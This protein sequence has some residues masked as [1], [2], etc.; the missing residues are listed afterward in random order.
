EEQ[1]SLGISVILDAVFPRPE[2]RLKMKALADH[3]HAGFRPI[4]CYCSDENTWQERVNN[5]SMI[6][7]HWTPVKWEAVIE[8]RSYF[9][10]WNP[11]TALFIDAVHPLI[12]NVDLIL[13]W[14]NQD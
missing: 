10:N 13:K 3:F 4:Y 11:G 8:I 6:V 7:P 9:R 1:L 14:L 12:D 2:F 5:R